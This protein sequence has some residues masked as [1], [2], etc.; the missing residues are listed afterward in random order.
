[1]TA[2]FNPDRYRTRYSHYRA[3]AE[4][5]LD[6]GVVLHTVELAYGDRA[7]EVTEPGNALHV[8]LRT[9]DDMW[10]KENLQNIAVVRMLPECKYL[11][12]I[13]A[14]IVMTRR[15]WAYE[16][17]H[18]MQRYPVVQ[19]FSSM[20]GLAADFS[21][22]TVIPS[23]MAAWRSGARPVAGASGWLGA[24][25]GAW[26]MTREAYDT[27]GGL[28]DTEIVGSADWHM[29]FGLLQIEDPS[30]HHGWMTPEHCA[31]ISHWAAGARALNA[32]VGCV[33]NH[34]VHYYHG[35]Y[36]QRGYDTRGAILTRHKFDPATDLVRNAQ[37]LLQ[38]AGN[39]PQ[40]QNEI[41]AYLEARADDVVP[42]APPRPPVPPPPPADPPKY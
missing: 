9:R 5:M 4:H 39:K 25:G 23:Y 33:A 40:M 20:S 2:I 14:D 7:F 36:N 31:T 27:L 1:V 22:D 19:L 26:A 3:F 21:H 6:S 30:V 38:F 32:R 29:V 10:Y 42:P 37:G 13:D 28:L 11:A 15:D 17:V 18:L 16:A 8:Q 34:A 24:T 41:I 12:F 35:P